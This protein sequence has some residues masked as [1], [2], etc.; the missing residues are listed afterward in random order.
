MKYSKLKLKWAKRIIGARQLVV[1][2]DKSSVIM[3]EGLDPDKLQDVTVLRAQ[4][5]ELRHYHTML[6]SLIRRHD[7]V[8]KRLTA[9]KSV[10][11][12]KVKKG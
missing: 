4:S 10:R 11:T 9:K 3:L 5:A 8:I 12:I 2:T 1:L 7:L 6:G